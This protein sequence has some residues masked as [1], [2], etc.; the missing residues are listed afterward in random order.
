MRLSSIFLVGLCFF[1]LPVS[2]AETSFFQ[3][4][5]EACQSCACGMAG[6]MEIIHN[7]V[8]LA[9]ALA[10]LIATFVIVWSGALFIASSANPESRSK[11][12][13]MLIQAA[14]GMIIVLGA[15]LAIDAFMRLL[16]S[17]TDGS[18]GVWRPWNSIVADSGEYCIAA[19]PGKSLF[20]SLNL[21]QIPNAEP[22]PS[23]SNP[24]P[25]QPIPGP[26]EPLTGSD[27]KFD[28][29]NNNI[30]AQA[31][32]ASP[33]L[34]SFLSCMAAKVPGNVGR[35]SSISDENITPGSKTFAQCVK[36]GCNHAAGSCH[37]GGKLCT[38]QSYA[39]DF[40]DENNKATL[41]TAAAACGADFRLDEGDHLH[42]SVGGSCSCN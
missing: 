20:D 9:I 38:G 26:G 24:N 10:V 37:Y 42:F 13:G 14:I 16:Y 2:A 41:W 18:E 23:P 3:I 28:Y 35:I 29:D 4:V 7:V 17:G 5:P 6:V 32:D 34:N 1:A 11:A 25:S 19:K 15:W 12:R 22:I 31:A 36:G 8:N 21:G 33:R 30:R 27:G 40:G 39:V